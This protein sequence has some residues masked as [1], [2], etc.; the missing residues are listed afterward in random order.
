MPV[1]DRVKKTVRRVKESVSNHQERHRPSGFQFAL[2]DSVAM[3]R[4]DHWDRLTADESVYFSRKYLEVLEANAPANLRMHYALI[5]KDG[6]PLA[7]VVAQAV[8]V[9]GDAVPRPDIQKAARASLARVKERILVC[10]NLLSWG[11][12]GVASAKEADPSEVWPAVAEA[13]YRIRRADKLFGDT[14]LVMIKDLDG[15]VAASAGPLS[16]FNYRPLETEPNMVFHV[17]PKWGS[18][19]D[20]LK[21]LRS[22]YRNAA[23]KVM[24]DF[25]EAGCTLE[26]LDA[27]GVKAH[28]DLIHGLYHQ[29]H[30][31]QKLRLI[32]LNPDFIPALAET[33]GAGFRTR[34]ARGLGGEPVGF[35]TT[36]KDQDGAVGYYIG[37][38]KEAAAQGTPIYL[39]LLQCT[40]EDAIGMKARWLSLGRTAL[41]PKAQ[42]GAQPVPLRCYVRHRI[43]AMNAVVRGFLNFMPEPDTAPERN[44]FK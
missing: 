13:L 8:E 29:V 14:G 28:R 26:V 34:I 10:G 15:E 3:L 40:I 23:K 33:F 6:K 7:A 36:L 9:R 2:F 21:D 30:D 1:L 25:S 35:I 22:G 43:P 4:P 27:E 32:S 37:F 11:F 41:Q 16:R 44:P 20:Y 17:D 5:Y 42:L 19:E 24:K 31:Q 39:R 12:H 38:D 18:F